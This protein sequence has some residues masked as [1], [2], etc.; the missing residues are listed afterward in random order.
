MWR[1]WHYERLNG[2][3]SVDVF[4]SFTYD[5]K[6][7]GLKKVSFL[8]RGFRYERAPDGSRKIDILFVPVKR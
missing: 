1:L 2:N 8:W 4:P 3:V 7:D 5:R 6:T